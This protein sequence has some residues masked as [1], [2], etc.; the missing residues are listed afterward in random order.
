MAR[1]VKVEWGWSPWSRFLF[2]FRGVI[3]GAHTVTF[4]SPFFF[5]LGHQ[6]FLQL[7]GAH[8]I[9]VS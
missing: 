6:K 2:L 4:S 9:T 8:Q 5:F 3:A 7:F 1:K